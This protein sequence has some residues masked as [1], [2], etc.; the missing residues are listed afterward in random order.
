MKKQFLNKIWIKITIAIVV[1][2]LII[3]GLVSYFFT[4]RQLSVERQEIRN[5]M[6]RVAKQIASIRLAETAGWFVYQEWIDNIIASDIGK[7]LV[8]IAIFDEN[9]SLAAFGINYNWLDLGDNSYL[10]REEQIRVVENLANGL[11]AEESQNDFDH[12]S[13]NIRLGR[14]LLGKVDVG[15]SLVDFNNRFRQRAFVNLYL[16]LLFLLIG[17]IAS[18][19]IGRRITRPINQLS[20][21]MLQVSNGNLENT[22]SVTSNDETGSLAQSYNYMI[23][24][25]REK[26]SIEQF[27]KQLGFTYTLEELGKVITEHIVRSMNA[28]RGTLLIVSSEVNTADACILYSYPDTKYNNKIVPISQECKSLLLE[29]QTAFDIAQLEQNHQQLVSDTFQDH[30]GFLKNQIFLPLVN[31]NIL[32]GL[33]LVTKNAQL[34]YSI[35]E[36][37]FLST[38]GKQAA[39][40]LENANLLKEVTEKERLSREL[41]IARAVQQ[42]L[43]PQQDPQ[44]KGL[45]IS[46]VCI[47]TA[48]IGGDYYDYFILDKKRIG[49]AIAD[50]SGKGASAA[51]YM[52]EIKGMMSALAYTEKSPKELLLNVNQ[53]LYETIDRKI[54]ATMIY[55]IIDLNDN[56]FKFVRAGHNALLI[57]R[58][59]LDNQVEMH[60]PPGIGLGLADNKTFEMY[61]NEECVILNKQDT[62]LFYTDGITEAMNKTYQEYGEDQLVEFLKNSNNQTSGA[63]L[64]SLLHDVNKFS[65][66]MDQFDDITLIVAKITES[67]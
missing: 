37:E 51:F 55:G 10:T 22:L 43:L 44:I 36:L 24:R 60:I 6:G 1:L 39:L 26:N 17:V 5:N 28:S 63:L 38:L 56:S 35:D 12:F 58:N 30:F 20:D 14:E 8:Y 3:M 31:Q 59:Q 18:V 9:N 27:T 66:D 16:L 41:E 34:Q 47:S 65:G 33:F 67:I 15:F 52:S 46:G 23:S 32:L 25:L 42:R 45:D 54:F 21:A 4:V 64:K 29:K 13:V 50:V 62:L 19:I 61:L 2:I 53:R 48:E 57:A 49:I 11:V 7:D 40:A